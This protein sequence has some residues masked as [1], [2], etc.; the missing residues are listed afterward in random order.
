MKNKCGWVLQSL[1]QHLAN[2]LHLRPTLPSIDWN[3]EIVNRYEWR[4]FCCGLCSVMT[5]SP[6]SLP[7]FR[8]CLYLQRRGNGYSGLAE[9]GGCPTPPSALI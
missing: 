4:P 8:L 5:N 7:E 2:L 3:S 1:G 9:P 6:Y